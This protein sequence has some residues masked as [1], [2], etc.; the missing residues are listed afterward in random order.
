MSF[1][2]QLNNSKIYYRN[3]HTIQ[4][5]LLS[6]NNPEQFLPTIPIRNIPKSNRK[7]HIN[8][9]KLIQS[10]K[11]RKSFKNDILS[12]SNN[13]NKHDFITKII[14]EN[15]P[16]PNDVS[17]IL[18][19]YIYK[20]KVSSLYKS[21]YE[22]NTM[23]FFFAEEKVALDFMNLLFQEKKYNPKYYNTKIS[24]NL[25]EQTK[26]KLPDINQKIAREVLRR[27]Y[28]GFGYEKK[29][30]PKKKIL[31]NINFG[32]ESPFYNVNKKKM[33]KNRSEINSK[34][35]NLF[36]KVLKEHKGDK[37]GYIGYD[38]KPLKSYKTLN[39]N[40]LNTSYKPISSFIVRDVDKNKWMSPMDFKMY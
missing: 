6:D 34:E 14:I 27:L 3:N 25:M 39:I 5:N 23:I 18:E 9:L 1:I 32:M 19:N 26:K 11:I 37:F 12:P 31:G 20:N 22:L 30:K 10:P 29:E 13:S 4:N 28:Y 35:K 17:F 7:S 8:N 24:I 2:D 21:L 16:S 40:L 15:P 36:K 33:K 38:G